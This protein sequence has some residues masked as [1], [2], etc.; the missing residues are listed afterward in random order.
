MAHVGHQIYA[1]HCKRSFT[2]VISCVPSNSPVRRVTI[3][4]VLHE[5]TERVLVRPRG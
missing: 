3:F 2:K 1:R 4:S 5:A